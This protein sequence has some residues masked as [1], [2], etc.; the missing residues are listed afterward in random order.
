MLVFRH[1]GTSI[2]SETDS[3]TDREIPSLFDPPGPEIEASGRFRA[4]RSGARPP[5]KSED[6]TPRITICMSTPKSSDSV[7]SDASAYP[8]GSVSPFDNRARI[9]REG[10]S[11]YETEA[12]VTGGPNLCGAPTPV[13][14]G[15]RSSARDIA[16]D[17]LT[18]VF[19]RTAMRA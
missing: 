6:G 8:S 15:T 12:E 9:V 3:D 13:T 18:P 1:L 16:E 10:R 5:V 7:E 14:F 2:N 19:A 17:A 4:G 11:S